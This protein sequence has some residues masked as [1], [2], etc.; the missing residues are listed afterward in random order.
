MP[1]NNM[2]IRFLH[3]YTYHG[4]MSSTTLSTQYSKITVPFA[5]MTS[6]FS[7]LPPELWLAIVERTPQLRSFA[8]ANK[9]TP[10]VAAD[11]LLQR[12]INNKTS[13]TLVKFSSVLR[14]LCA[15]GIADRTA[16]SLCLVSSSA[17][18]Q[19]RSTATKK[20]SLPV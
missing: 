6:D 8:L 9:T 5:K 10:Q 15:L 18:R 19:R 14:C 11:T 20:L 17:E 2:G 12:A 1:Q 13:H 4:H 3:G 16:R 7:S